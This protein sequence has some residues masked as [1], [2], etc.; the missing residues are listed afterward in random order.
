MVVCA[1][2]VN[3]VEAHAMGELD[4][5]IGDGGLVPEA[6]VKVVVEAW[7]GIV[8][9]VEVERVGAHIVPGVEAQKL[10]HGK[11]LNLAAELGKHEGVH[12]DEEAE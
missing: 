3:L 5:D 10:R 12:G 11:R 1:D 9:E 6:V 2:E 8:L 7:G 4:G